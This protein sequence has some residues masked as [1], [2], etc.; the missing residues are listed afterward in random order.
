VPGFFVCA[1]FLQRDPELEGAALRLFLRAVE[2]CLR[3]HSAGVGPA[4]RLGAVAF[5]HRF[6]SALNPQLHVHRVVIDGVFE[7]APADAVVLHAA[8]GLDVNAI[9]QCSSPC[10]GGWCGSSCAVVC[11]RAMMHRRRRNRNMAVASPSMPRC[12]SRPLTA[13]AVTS[14]CVTAPGHR[15]PWT[16][17]ANS[18]PNYLP[19]K[20]QKPGPGGNG[21]LLTSW[22]AGT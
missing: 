10:A 20:S 14:H 12:A 16:G 15:S 17:G 8:T 21:P 18:I 19:Y 13:P 4:A 9:A 6:G 3:A 22:P 2:Q 7:S 5:I 1:Y 11:Y